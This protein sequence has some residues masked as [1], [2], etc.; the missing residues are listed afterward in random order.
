VLK[1]PLASS[2]ALAGMFRLLPGVVDRIGC[3]LHGG[4]VGC[5][6]LA[7]LDE[8]PCRAALTSVATVHAGSAALRSAG[9]GN[10][11][12]LAALA[13][14]GFREQ[15]GRVRSGGSGVDVGGLIK[16]SGQRPARVKEKPCLVTR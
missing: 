12:R 7:S 4:P 13:A 2:S 8:E 14:D 3:E 1:R 11:E 10:A 5:R 16:A 9:I 6:V 15:L